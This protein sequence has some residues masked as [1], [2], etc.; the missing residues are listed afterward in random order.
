MP[1]LASWETTNL[2]SCESHRRDYIHPS[3]GTLLTLH[4]GCKRLGHTFARITAPIFHQ[5]ER[6]KIWII[7]DFINIV[8]WLEFNPVCISSPPTFLQL[9]I[10]FTPQDI[11]SPSAPFPSPFQ[12]PCI[13]SDPY[14]VFYSSHLPKLL[15]SPSSSPS[16]PAWL[17][18]LHLPALF[19]G[20]KLVLALGLVILIVI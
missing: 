7:G 10:S 12:H 19:I 5:L 16:H 17:S 3:H 9:V 1:C 2:T 11:P 13:F 20:H 18:H 4:H 15:S 14:L 6:L 8:K